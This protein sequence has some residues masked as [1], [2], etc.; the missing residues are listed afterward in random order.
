LI[1][2]WSAAFCL[3]LAAPLW[4]EPVQPAKQAQPLEQLRLRAEH[5][6]DGV[7]EGNL[8]GLAWCG[9]GL[10]TVSDRVDDRLYRLVPGEPV[11]QVEEERFVAPPPPPSGLPWG[12]RQGNQLLGLLRG[13][14][15]DFEGL[16]CDARGNRYLLSE[17]QLGVLLIPPAGMPRWLS[18]PPGLVRQARASGMLLRYNALYEGIAVDPVSSRLWLAVERERRGLLVLHRQQTGWQCNGGCV[19]LAESGIAAPPVQSGLTQPQPLDFSDLAFY[20]ER[21]YT[22]ERMAHQICRRSLKTGQAERC[23]SFAEEGLSAS[24]RYGTPDGVAEGLWLD[25][26][27]AWVMLDNGRLPRGDGERRP[28]LWQFAA[29]ANGWSAAP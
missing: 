24:R 13:G 8:S 22:L 19:L 9:N 26:E 2:I 16:S 27:N 4:A 11:W 3:L 1:R 15:L 20:Q 10:W 6:I 5:V 29:P 18:L 14:E 23:W 25:G 12:V 28:I 17:T 21:L 7:P